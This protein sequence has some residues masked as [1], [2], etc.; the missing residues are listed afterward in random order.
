[1]Q[2]LIV[3]GA[4]RGTLQLIETAQDMG[5]YSI[6]V[7]PEGH[8]RS[9]DSFG[10]DE[11]W[12]FATTDIDGI[13]ARA[14]E[15]DVAGGGI[16][17]G[18]SQFNIGNALTI[19]DRLSLPFYCDQSSW[20]YTVDKRAFKELCMSCGVPVAKNYQFSRRADGTIS[21][22]E[23]EFPI[24]VK[25]VDLSA[26]R[27]MSYC[28]SYDE[29]VPACEKALELSASDTVIIEKMMRGREYTAHYAL[30]D[31]EASLINFCSM[32]HQPGYPSNCY[33]FTST[34]TERLGQFLGEVDAPFRKALK[35]GGMREG[36]AWIELMLDD[37]NHFYV[38]EMGY[39]MSGDLWA[40]PMK[41]V[42][43]FDTYKWL[44]ECAIYGGHEKTCLPAPQRKV[45]E[46]IGCSYIIWSDHAGEVAILNGLGEVAALA[47]SINV[48]CSLAVG[49]RVSKHS[50]MM[51]ITFAAADRHEVE[52]I[53]G[54]INRMIVVEDI[55]G[56]D[57]CIRFDDYNSFESA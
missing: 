34:E 30:A 19:A 23:L 17:T 9:L 37:D 54:D 24:V 43:S 27:G 29:V 33:S 13:V 28:Y 5:I 53:V 55:N 14:Q 50:Y 51:V 18:I 44:I 57:L 12:T 56:E 21:V 6:L 10:A 38:L 22:P 1:M 39:R 16:L 25:A 41:E 35:K 36:V 31:G 52:K 46:R 40:L 4:S 32:F 7:G 49:D 8:S 15:E 20:Q 48:D 11:V 45:P 2:K 47:P 3:L 26:N 42:C